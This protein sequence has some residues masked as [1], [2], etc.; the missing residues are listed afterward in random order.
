MNFNLFEF[1]QKSNETFGLLPLFFEQKD[2]RDGESILKTEQLCWAGIFQVFMGFDTIQQLA[3]WIRTSQLAQSLLGTK[4][5]E[6]KGSDSTILEAAEGWDIRRLRGMAHKILMKFRELGYWSRELLTGREI[7][8]CA[9]DGTCFGNH[10]MAVLSLLGDGV[11]APVDMEAYE[12]KGKEL[13]AARRILDRLGGGIK[14]GLTHC[15]VDGL[16]RAKDFFRQLPDESLHWIVKTTEESLK[17][18]RWAQQLFEECATEKDL[19][20]YGVEL[21]E[22]CDLQRK[23]E[24]S[25]WYVSGVPWEEVDRTLGVARVRL[26]FHEGK[27]K[28]ETE[29]F[30][31]LCTDEELTAVELREIA[32]WRWGIENNLFR[33]LNQRV[34]SKNAYIHND[35]TKETLLWLWMIGWSLFQWFRIEK[36][37]VIDKL[38]GGAAVTKKWLTEILKERSCVKLGAAES[39]G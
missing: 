3:G 33:E 29:I 36:E 20:E 7:R 5:Q 6:A 1:K 27:R 8:L 28:G 23:V 31:V 24:Y 10:W 39:E 18:I 4:T 25:I 12:K 22:A 9:L 26:K 13:T 2:G 16:Y 17:P 19:R 14:K 15:V 35:A 37:K 32:L 21:V 34:G 11:V 30:W 38:A